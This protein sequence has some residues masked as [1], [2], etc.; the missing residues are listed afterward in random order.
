MALILRQEKHPDG[1]G[2][3]T[4]LSWWET[5]SDSAVLNTAQNRD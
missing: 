4:A 1:V 3:K 5:I 2:E